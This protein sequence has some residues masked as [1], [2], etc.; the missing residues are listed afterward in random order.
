MLGHLGTQCLGL[1]EILEL[2]HLLSWI[3]KN[4]GF[5]APPPG[6]GVLAV[7]FSG[8]AL[9]LGSEIGG[10]KLGMTPAGRCLNVHLSLL[11]QGYIG[12]LSKEAG[13]SNTMGWDTA[14]SLGRR[15]LEGE[16][17]VRPGSSPAFLPGVCQAPHLRRAA[18][19]ALTPGSE[20]RSSPDWTAGLVKTVTWPC[21]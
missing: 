5:Q 13:I 21:S 19:G 17:K 14:R 6:K 16:V 10:L 4:A 2:F 1:Q 9:N 7:C 12:L 8:G 3:R 15:R 20:A 11:S 18:P